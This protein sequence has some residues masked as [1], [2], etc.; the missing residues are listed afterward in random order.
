MALAL[1]RASFRKLL[2][3][4]IRNQRGL[5]RFQLRLRP[6]FRRQ[7]WKA[8]R[9]DGTMR[10]GRIVVKGTGGNADTPYA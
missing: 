9:L 8:V 2:L 3:W 6:A 4:L 5:S 7:P 1:G 10:S